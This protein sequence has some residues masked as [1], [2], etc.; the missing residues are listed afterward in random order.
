MRGALGMDFG[1]LLGD[2]YGV[3]LTIA[4]TGIIKRNKK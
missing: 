2:N 1:K 4:K 3:Q